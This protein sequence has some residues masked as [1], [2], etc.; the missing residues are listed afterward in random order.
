MKDLTAEVE[1]RIIKKSVISAP[2]CPPTPRPAEPIALGADHDPSSSFAM[3]IPV[4]ALAEKRKPALKT[5]KIANPLA[6]SNTL[7]GMTPSRPLFL[8]ST[9][10]EKIFA[11]LVHSLGSVG[12]SGVLHFIVHY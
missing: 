4:P 1:L 7:R 9:N 8:L 12:G 5:V 10:E 3:T 11:A 6:F 2:S